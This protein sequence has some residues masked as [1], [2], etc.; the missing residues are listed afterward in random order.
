MPAPGRVL[1]VIDVYYPMESHSIQ[2]V[3]EAVLRPLLVAFYMGT[4]V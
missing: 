4:Q 1:A 2:N 3:T